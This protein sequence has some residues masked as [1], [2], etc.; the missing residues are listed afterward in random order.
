[1]QNMILLLQGL[2]H[3]TC[4]GS[5]F[6]RQQPGW[7]PGFRPLLNN[8]SLVLEMPLDLS[9]TSLPSLGSLSYIDK[10]VTRHSG[11]FRVPFR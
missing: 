7:I 11:R 5:A 8:F 3:A 4:P 9:E 6:L 10:T 2:T 1:M